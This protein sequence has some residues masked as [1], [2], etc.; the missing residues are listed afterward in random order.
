MAKELMTMSVPPP[1][2]AQRY[3]Y[4]RLEHAAD[5]L[6]RASLRERGQSEYPCHSERWMTLRRRQEETSGDTPAPA[7]AALCQHLKEL[8]DL[9]ISETPLP[10]THRRVL[11]L[12]REGASLTATARRMRRPLS[13][14]HRWYHESHSRVRRQAAQVLSR[15]TH[16]LLIMQAYREQTSPALY[17]DE[18]HCAPGHEDCRRDGV[19]R[20]R[21]YLYHG[22][23]QG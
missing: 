4:K 22:A 21:W 13:T 6:L 10:E 18:H 17:Q 1:A 14:V 16:P 11:E 3:P 8:L 23:P 2:E 7:D 20:H 5:A 12:A 9:L 15:S 19:C